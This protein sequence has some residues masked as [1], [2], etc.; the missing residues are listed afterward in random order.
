MGVCR[1]VE[2]RLSSEVTTAATVGWRRPILL[3]SSDWPTWTHAELRA[4]LAHELAHISRADYAAWLLAN[5]SVAVHFYHPLVYWLANRLRL[6]QELAADALGALHAGG[7]TTY[8]RSLARLALRQDCS[9]LPGPARAFLPAQ[10]TL[11]R[12]IAMLREK[13][14]ASHIRPSW[15]VRLG[16]PALIGVVALGVSTLRL[17][18]QQAA[19]DQAPPTTSAA[20]A[21]AEFNWSYVPQDADGVVSFHPSEI[22]ARPDVQRLLGEHG[23][24]AEALYTETSK[25]FGFV[26]DAQSW[27]HLAEI[28]QVSAGIYIGVMAQP[29]NG[30]SNYLMLAGATVHT[31]RDF[32]WKKLAESLPKAQ[33][34]FVEVERG[35]RK[36]YK[37]TKL[38]FN[39]GATWC[40]LIPDARTF[41]MDTEKN[42]QGILDAKNPRKF[43]WSEGWKRVSRSLVAITLENGDNRI[44]LRLQDRPTL[45]PE[46]AEVL[47]NV[48]QLAFG[49]DGQDAVTFD[50]RLRCISPKAAAST[51]ETL[52][53]ALTLAGSL[54]GSPQADI[55]GQQKTAMLKMQTLIKAME[56]TQRESEVGIQATAQ[57][58]LWD[59]LNMGGGQ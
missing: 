6:H 54:L 18:A 1:T 32:D 53:K 35:G 17:P 42:V 9:P 3:L 39:T 21:R 47:K 52:K 19:P 41:V 26:S 38:P 24:D 37:W 48:Q 5:V 16:L 45:T 22:L 43:S 58:T 55:G 23:V 2:I 15:K 44:G 51:A 31:T 7:A 14:V 12:R 11:M 33:F 30:H 34:E 46:Y 50:Y 40:F 13:D 28:E 4:V 27:P 25:T 10:G 56:V 59:L 8:R 49:F 36:Y 20:A 29:T 57:M